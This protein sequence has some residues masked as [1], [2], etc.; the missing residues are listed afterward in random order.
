MARTASS[1]SGRALA[2]APRMPGTWLPWPGRSTAVGVMSSTLCSVALARSTHNAS[3]PPVGRP[4]PRLGGYIAKQ[5]S[6]RLDLLANV[7]A[8]NPAR[9]VS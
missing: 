5:Q 6:V 3:P 7:S 9:R 2:T 1:R 4:T 8:L